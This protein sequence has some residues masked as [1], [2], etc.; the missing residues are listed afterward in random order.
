MKW[1][2]VLLIIWLAASAGF[3]FGLTIG[4][5]L[6]ANRIWRGY[7]VPMLFTNEDNRGKAK[8]IIDAARGRD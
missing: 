6:C 2:Y 4:F 7:R 3:V 8:D 1:Y 5:R